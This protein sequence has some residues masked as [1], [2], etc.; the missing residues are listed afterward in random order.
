[1]RVR[2]GDPLIDIHCPSPEPLL[3]P[4][5]LPAAGRGGRTAFAIL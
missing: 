1:M 3:I 5:D 4:S 2:T